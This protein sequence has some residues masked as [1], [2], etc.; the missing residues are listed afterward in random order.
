MKKPL[1]M[2]SRR[3]ASLFA[4]PVYA[5]R[6]WRQRRIL[7]LAEDLVVKA[8][9]VRIVEQAEQLCSLH[10]SNHTDRPAVGYA[11]GDG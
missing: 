11:D 5:A 4:G 2:A 9:A 3:T 1:T 7:R 10:A 6:R 8:A